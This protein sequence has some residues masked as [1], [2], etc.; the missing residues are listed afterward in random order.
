MGFNLN[1][2]VNG[3]PVQGM[4]SDVVRQ[5]AGCESFSSE[6]SRLD[7]FVSGDQTVTFT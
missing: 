4:L 6:L 2:L 1:R 3:T 5:P 7:Q